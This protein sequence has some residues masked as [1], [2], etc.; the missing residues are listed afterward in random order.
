MAKPELNLLRLRYIETVDFRASEHTN[1]LLAIRKYP[2][3]AKLKPKDAV[4]LISRKRDQL[5]FVYGFG[6]TT[7]LR[8]VR[9]Y[10]RSERL[11]LENGSWDPLML[12][13]YAEEAGIFLEGIKTLEEHLKAAKKA[14]KSAVKGHGGS[15]A[16]AA[17]AV[18]TVQRYEAFH[19]VGPE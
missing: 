1:Y 9:R 16:S 2:Y 10:L 12:Q 18:L 3:L 19:S 8:G 17:K 4:L 11:R 7:G 6:I 14:M 13:N 5:I 15:V